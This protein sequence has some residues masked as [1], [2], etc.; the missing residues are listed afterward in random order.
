MEPIV[1]TSSNVNENLRSDEQPGMCQSNHQQS[2]RNGEI[3]SGCQT[4]RL[5]VLQRNLEMQK[6]G[7]RE[8]K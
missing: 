7:L 3:N 2:V 8:V 4:G 1:K 5:F 6:V